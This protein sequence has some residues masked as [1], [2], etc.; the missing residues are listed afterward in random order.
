MLGRPAG[1]RGAREGPRR[2]RPFLQ[3]F[4]RLGPQPEPSGWTTEWSVVLLTTGRS[5]F[6][7]DARAAN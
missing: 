5:L 1:S 3:L 2:L 6:S 7:I 4:L